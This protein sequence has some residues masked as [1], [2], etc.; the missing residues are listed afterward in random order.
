MADIAEMN[1]PGVP[2][3]I[4]VDAQA[5]AATPDEWPGIVAPF[6][7]RVA[8]VDYIPKASITANGT[9]FFTLNIRNRGAAGSG[10]TATASRSWAATNSTAWVGEKFTLNATPANR[11][12]NKGDV[13]TVERTVAASGLASPAATVVIWLV[14]S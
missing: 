5:T 9:N 1:D 8:R 3:A 14:A 7:G 2:F 11:R 13:L 12:F 4:A 10:T 6:A